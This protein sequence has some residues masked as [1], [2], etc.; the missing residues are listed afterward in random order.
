MICPQC[1]YERQKKDAIIS[2]AECPRC[3]IIY[4]KWKSDEPAGSAG[5]PSTEPGPAV[6]PPDGNKKFSL[7]KL[8]IYAG[9]AVVLIILLHSFVVPGFIKLYKAKSIHGPLHADTAGDDI[10]PVQATSGPKSYMGATAQTGREGIVTVRTHSGITGS[11]FFLNRNGDIVTSGEVLTQG[12]AAI[13]ITS[14]GRS[15]NVVEVVAASTR[16]GLVIASTQATPHYAIPLEINTSLPRPGEKVIVPGGNKQ[17]A[18]SVSGEIVSIQ[19]ESGQGVAFIEVS[20]FAAPVENGAPLLNVT[21]E[22]IA[23]AA[24]SYFE[25]RKVNRFIAAEEIISLDAER[26]VFSGVAENEV[27]PSR[28]RDVYCYV[29]SDG[30]VSFVEWKTQMLLTLPDGSLDGENFE[31]W[32]IEQVGG[33]PDYINPD[34]E[35]QEDLERNREKLFKSV[36]PH[37]SMSDT[38]LTDGEKSWLETRYRQ[39]YTEVYNR[40]VARRNDAVRKYNIM[41][42][43]F[44][45]FSAERS[46]Q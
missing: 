28:G 43:D 31:K 24:L 21:G 12:E 7:E 39:H 44:Q 5:E 25:G 27:K 16:S 42:G 2:F 40:W 35:A 22:V 15:F 14:A 3:G 23:V 10:S 29:G 9:I 37:R 33:N 30:H 8:A 11:G 18:R 32:V 38:N 17:A 45:R 46:R 4:G 20:A 36:F 19:R 34:K 41:M 26:S 13:I 1:G 6:L